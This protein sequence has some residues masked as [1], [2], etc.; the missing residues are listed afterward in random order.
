MKRIYEK[1][2][3]LSL[4]PVALAEETTVNLLPGGDFA[5]LGDL[6]FGGLVSAGIRLVLII[7]AVIFFF[8][9]VWGGIAW[10]MSGGDKAQTENARN[11]IT[12]A[13]VG[14]VIVFAAWAII[15]LVG[16]FFGVE[17]LQDLTIPT[18]GETP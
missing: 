14:L 6:T 13:L 4:V 18:A 1:F 2:A 12:S 16:T 5:N 7:A 8:Y 10:I 11:R 15:Q 9:L 3:F 17:L